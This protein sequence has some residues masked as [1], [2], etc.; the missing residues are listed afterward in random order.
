MRENNRAFIYILPA[1][2]GSV[3]NHLSELGCRMY[4][5]L[6]IRQ[7][8]MENLRLPRWTHPVFS[9]TLKDAVICFS[10]FDKDTKL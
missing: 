8:V 10:G 7:S 4:G 6:A 3:F 5:T 1:F 2:R 9:L